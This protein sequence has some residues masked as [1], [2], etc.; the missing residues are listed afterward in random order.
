MEAAYPSLDFIECS[1]RKTLNL[2]YTWLRNVCDPDDW[3]R[4]FAILDMTTQEQ[5]LQRETMSRWAAP[6]E[7]GRG[8]FKLTRIEPD[9]PL[10]EPRMGV[11]PAK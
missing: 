3:K 1:L 8:S 7:D 6:D 10:V 2:T 11:T 9:K 5:E 4:D